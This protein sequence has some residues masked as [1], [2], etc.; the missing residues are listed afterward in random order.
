MNNLSN[1]LWRLNHLYTIID[2]RAQM[3]VFQMNEAQLKVYAQL[4]KHN[5]LLILK[6]RQQGISTL[7]F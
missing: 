6:S 2:T 4:L 5:R 1:Q 7:S 3:C